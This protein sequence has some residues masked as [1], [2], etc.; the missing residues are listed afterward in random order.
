[1]LTFLGPGSPRPSTPAPGEVFV[2]AVEGLVEA[3]Y[4]KL[5][6]HR[7]T[8]AEVVALN[9]RSLAL[10]AALGAAL[11]ETLQEFWEAYSGWFAMYSV[12]PLLAN[13]R[14]G[15]QAL[16]E[17]PDSQARLL[18]CWRGGGW[19][20]GRQLLHPALLDLLADAGYRTQVQPGA[21]LQAL[22]RGAARLGAG[23]SGAAGLR[24]EAARA[25][26]HSP[27]S[28]ATP[29][30]LLWLSVGASSADLIARVSSA[31]TE[32]GLPS[33]ILD[34]HYYGSA[35]ALRRKGL[36]FTDISALVGAEALAAGEQVRRSLRR[37][38]PA[39]A[40]AARALPA[41]TPLPPRMLQAVLDRL[42]TV[43][44]RH[45]PAW[46]VQRLAA[47]A[48]LDAYQPRVVLGTHVY[49]PAI[50]PFVIAARHRGLPTICLQH[51]VIGPRYLALPSLPY[52]EQ[53]LFGAY[54]AQIL[55]QVCSPHTRL[56]VTGHCLY[57]EALTPP[58][59]RPE[60]LALREGAAG[61]VVVCTQFNEQS[62]YRSYGWW[63]QGVADA[64]RRLAV[65][66][67]LKLHP[68]DSAANL[69]LY[70]TLVQAG[71]DRVSLAPH[72]KWPLLELLAA[73]DVMV[74][75][76]STVVFEANLLGKPVVTVNLSDWD[77]ELPYAGTGGAL[78][79]YHYGDI[80]PALAAALGDA[81]VR[82]QLAESRAAFLA[83]HTG[84]PD[85]K[86]T[87][88]IVERLAAWVSDARQRGLARRETAV[89]LQQDPRT[90]PSADD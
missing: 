88:R 24:E 82:G 60:V 71:D 87:E 32:A 6:E 27:T 81:T 78:G 35:E 9:Q 57:D 19:W 74:T 5:P 48:A 39:I 76:D 37:Q 73:C 58:R 16:R 17:H 80:A 65:R 14:V 36:A 77:E 1:M 56:T 13:A 34:F 42:Q 59:P 44:Q 84:P 51:G 68:S 15:E 30:D 29:A 61:L 70:Q 40:A 26:R 31:A 83:A 20:S 41:L 21:A 63:L 33:A 52:S 25:Q 69:A 85:G 2:P 46:T 11:P 64:C 10:A 89:N 3:A 28:P 86:A 18:E 45:A 62:Y 7:E 72:G 66:L 53:L 50:A 79:V 22:R 43:L 38:W 23:R 67:V 12:G 55:A 90:S 49:G 47:E 75:R 54:A 8:R 4:S